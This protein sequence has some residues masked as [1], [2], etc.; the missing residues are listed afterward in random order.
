LSKDSPFSLWFGECG[1]LTRML[2][3]SAARAHALRLP[4]PSSP[5]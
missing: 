3:E 2:A 5:S 4:G 1:E